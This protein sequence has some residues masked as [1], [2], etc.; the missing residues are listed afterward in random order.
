MKTQ[1]TLFNQFSVNKREI[2]I[3]GHAYSMDSDKLLLTLD[4]DLFT[5]IS[6]KQDDDDR[7]FLTE[8]L[9]ESPIDSFYEEDLFELE[10]Y[11]KEQY[12]QETEKW[13]QFQK[14]LQYNEYLRL[15]AIFEPN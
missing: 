11:T 15:K 2:K 9:G 4:N 10:M 13:Y 1:T 12:K 7:Y 14:D 6:I 3:T 5:V 8:Q